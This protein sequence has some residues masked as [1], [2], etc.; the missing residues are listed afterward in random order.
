[1][2][3][4]LAITNFINISVTQAAPG[5]GSYN[6]SNLAIFSDEPVIQSVETLAFSGIA[7]SGTFILGFNG[8]NTASISFSD[9][10]TAIQTKINAVTGQSNVVV[11]GTIASQTLTLSQPGQLG[12]IP[13]VVVSSNS[14]QTAGSIAIT[15]TPTLT[16]AGWSGGSL[17]YSAYLTPSQVGIDFGTSSKTYQMANSV[18]S[19]QPNILNGSGQLIVILMTNV[20]NTIALSALAASGTFTVTY[21]ANT[22]AAINW[23]DTVAQLQTKIQAVPGLSSAVVTGSVAQQSL[24]IQMAGIYLPTALTATSSLLTGASA[25]ITFTITSTAAQSIG[26]AISAASSLVQFFG[27]MATESLD[28]IGQTDLLAAAAVI[29]SL[30]KISFFVSHTA[31]DISPGGMLDL[32][33]SGSFSQTRGLYYGDPV[34]VNDLIMM[35]AYAGRALS[36]NFS[37]SNTT[38]TMNLQSLTGVQPDP[39]LTQAQLNLANTAGADTY[40]SYQGVPGVYCSGA[41]QYFDAVYNLQWF[42][43]ALQVASFNYL[44]QAGTKIP[45]TES[46]MDGLK[47]ADRTVCEQ[48]FTNQ[49][50]APGT[51]NAPIPFGN[52]TLFLQN[53]SQK[54]Y[55]IYSV[56]VSQQLAADRAARKAP[57]IQIA[58][59]AA[60]AIQT[61]NVVVTINA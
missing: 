60:G 1:M 12:S 59:K 7:A 5:L 8:V 32:L 33:R 34:I 11:A 20:V 50:F 52:P 21:N 42:V 41:N 61:A 40:A 29:Q 53:I 27:A 16:S 2:A 14:L 54:G 46:G 30:N 48:A 4:Q 44:Q 6:T 19:Q 15:V 36:V 47:G 51:W 25:A 37:G 10:T 39:T 22:S 55:Y 56:P 49:Y 23:N 13:V 3:N 9:A 24:K 57:L 38:L 26:A 17:G 45:Q 31:A 43:G 18:F 58:G 28:I 35:A